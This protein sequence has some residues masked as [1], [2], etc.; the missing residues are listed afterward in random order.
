[1]KGNLAISGFM[2][3]V[4]CV[5]GAAWGGGTT[6]ELRSQDVSVREAVVAETGPHFVMD[7]NIPEGLPSDRLLGAILEFVVDADTRVDTTW[8][9]EAD[10]LKAF[11]HSTPVPMVE[12]YALTSSSGS[13]LDRRNWNEAMSFPVPVGVGSDKMVRI[14]ITRLVKRESRGEPRHRRGLA[15]RRSVRDLLAAGAFRR[16]SG[17]T[18][19]VRVLAACEYL[20]NERS[21]RVT[22]ERGPVLRWTKA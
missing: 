21:N 18:S 7:I 22:C 11:V 20:W 8:V 17:R 4:C 9:E 13:E 2:I 5:A 15:D 14:D 16:G 19:S 12:V 3:A 6:V 1:M 10:T